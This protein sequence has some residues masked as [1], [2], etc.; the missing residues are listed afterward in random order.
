M[1]VIGKSFLLYNKVDPLKVIF[2]KINAI[3]SSDLLEV[4]NTVLDEKQLS[5]ILYY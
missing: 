4:A 5:R 1:L 3:S 2:E